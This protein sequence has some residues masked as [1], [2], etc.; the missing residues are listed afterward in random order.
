MNI[1]ERLQNWYD[2]QCDDEWEHHHGL[3]IESQDNPGWVVTIDLKGTPSDA[4]PFE[5]IQIERAKNNWIVC[6]VEK[7]EFRGAGGVFNLV[8][9]LE[10]F[11]DWVEMN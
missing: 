10:I 3:T 1:L 4:K 8:E 5:E 7:G 6:R 9:I 11:L 2:F